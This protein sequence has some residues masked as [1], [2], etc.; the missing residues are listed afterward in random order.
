MP[1]LTREC[2]AAEDLDPGRAIAG[3]ADL[4]RRRTYVL[5]MRVPT[6]LLFLALASSGLCFAEAPERWTPEACNAVSPAAVET[7]DAAARWNEFYQRG[8]RASER[9]EHHLAE[10]EMCRALFAARSFGPRDWGFAETLDELG[11]I[12]FALR[13]YELAERM[14]GAAIAEMLLAVG[15][16]GEPFQDREASGQSPIRSDCRSGIQ[17]YTTR[18]GWIHEKMSGRIAVSELDQAPWRIFAVGYVPL[19]AHLAKR[20]DWLVSQYLL[21]ENLVAANEL[22]D[23]QRQI[24]EST[25]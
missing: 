17:V 13:D 8:F 16:H 15:P 1:A 7:P 19:D 14:Q 25:N 21:E 6:T 2:R 5:G 20:L 3:R 12:A 4:P 24:L 10:E 18:L 22:T 9:G 11:R 23:L